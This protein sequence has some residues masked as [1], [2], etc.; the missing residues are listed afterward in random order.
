MAAMA[1]VD[2]AV[3]FTLGRFDR[4]VV[5]FS[6]AVKAAS[7]AVLCTVRNSCQLAAA[8]L[9]CDELRAGLTTATQVVRLAKSL[10]SVSMQDDLAPL[11]QAA[12]R[13]DSACQDLA[14]E[15]TRLCAAA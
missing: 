10:R 13:R 12:A 8:Q 15:L 4:A 6:A 5:D 1:N 7:H 9:R 3:H 11:R 14:R 2:G